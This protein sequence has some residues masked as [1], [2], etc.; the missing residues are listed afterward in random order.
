MDGPALATRPCRRE[1]LRRRKPV[2]ARSDIR[3]AGVS[4]LDGLTAV[5]TEAFA[6]DP[7]WR[8][9]FPR[10]DGL[11]VWWRFLIASALRYPCVRVLG[12]FAAVAVWSPPGGVELTHEEEERVESVLDDLVGARAPDV[13]ALLDSFD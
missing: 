1:A 12:D 10:G 2:G 6:A 13:L 11:E 7:L 3:T 9:A 5:I 4:D 8:W